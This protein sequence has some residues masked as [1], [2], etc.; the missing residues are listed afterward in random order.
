VF[1]R[2]KILRDADATETTSEGK[3]QEVR[4]AEKKLGKG[5]INLLPGEKQPVIPV[6][7]PKSA[8]PPSPPPA[9]T[10]PGGATPNPTSPQTAE[11]PPAAPPPSTP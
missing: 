10:N 3:Y 6:I 5:H 9:I 2:P 11:P 1:I 4:E 7:P 8:L